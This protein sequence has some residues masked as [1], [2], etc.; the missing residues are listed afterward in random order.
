L[1]PSKASGT[2]ICTEQ[3]FS[4]V[5]SQTRDSTI[6]IL[7]KPAHARARALAYKTISDPYRTDRLGR[8]YK[9]GVNK[10]QSVPFASGQKIAIYKPE[11]LK[12]AGGLCLL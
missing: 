7:Y 10:H 1:H 2:K 3:I 11:Y 4:G 5:L 8:P 6:K 9:S 12:H